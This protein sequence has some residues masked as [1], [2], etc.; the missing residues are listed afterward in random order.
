MQNLK[1]M[2]IFF[3]I[4]YTLFV[5]INALEFSWNEIV[6]AHRKDFLQSEE[7]LSFSLWMRWERDI[8][9]WL[10]L[11]GYLTLFLFL[12]ICNRFVRRNNLGKGYHFLLVLLAFFP[13]ANWFLLYMIW[14]KLNKIIFTYMGRSFRR[15]DQFIILIWILM[16]VGA[17]SPIFVPLLTMYS[18]S[19]ESVS[20][21]MNFSY[22]GSLIRSVYLLIVSLLFLF[23]FLAFRRTI[24]SIPNHDEIIRESQLLDE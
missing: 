17:I 4:L 18:N 20:M 19:S 15:A 11:L 23:Y 7:L 16:L 3:I 21:A 8:H 14:R 13:I 10:N 6:F 22:W 1:R 5:L 12:I 9:F 2:T 24:Q